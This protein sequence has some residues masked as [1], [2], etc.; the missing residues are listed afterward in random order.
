MRTVSAGVFKV[1]GYTPNAPDILPPSRIHD[2]V[3]TSFSFA[4]STVTLSWTAVGDNLD[5]GTANIYELRYSND[6]YKVRNSFSDCNEVTD[7]QVVF[8][9]LSA[10]P[11]GTNKTVT[12]NLPERGSEIVYYFAIRAWDE[13]ENIGE[14]SNIASLSIRFVYEDPWAE[15]LAISISLAMIMAIGLGVAWMYF[16]Y[17][18]THI[19]RVSPEST[20]STDRRLPDVEEGQQD[21]PCNNQPSTSYSR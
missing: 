11:S 5:Q 15:D 20:A 13:A 2:L 10:T 21:R 4:R 3:Y 8:G 6:Y 12:I 18:T 1:E 7:D 19:I 14:I 9:N 16:H 17:Q